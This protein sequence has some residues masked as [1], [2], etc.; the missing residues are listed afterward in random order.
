MTPQEIINRSM[1]LKGQTTR[2]GLGLMTILVT[3]SQK[4]TSS[5]GVMIEFGTYIGRVSMLLGLLARPGEQLNLVDQADYLD[6]ESLEKEKI[7][8]KFYKQTSESYVDSGL[9]DIIN[10]SH[11][12]ASHYFENVRSEVA[13]IRNAMDPNGLIILDDFTDPYSQVRAAYYYLRYAENF[14]W[15][16]ILIGFGKGVLIHE[17]RFDFWEGWIL[18]DL[19]DEFLRLGVDTVLHRTD[20]SK[21]SRAFFIRGGN[22]SE[23]GRYGLNVWGERFYV[24]SK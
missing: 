3:A 14:P 21:H 15:E 2:N 18:K 16:L 23:P 4:M 20:I 22:G 8:Y 12:D 11:H 17:S 9:S 5:T 7:S 6:R 10:I 19:Q 13:G 24:Q 1:L